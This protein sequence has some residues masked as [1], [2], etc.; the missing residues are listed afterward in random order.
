MLSTLTII[1]DQMAEVGEV[2]SGEGE[3]KRRYSHLTKFW[4]RNTVSN[5]QTRK[6]RCYLNSEKYL[7]QKLNSIR[8]REDES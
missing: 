4:S 1:K 2:D 6:E 5:S 8:S 3:K 7:V